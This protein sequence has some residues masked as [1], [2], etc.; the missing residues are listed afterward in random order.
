MQDTHLK[1][2]QKKVHFHTHRTSERTPN[3]PK[4][5]STPKI[6]HTNEPE[7]GTQ[8][9]HTTIQYRLNMRHTQAHM[10]THTHTHTHAQTC[11]HLY[12]NMHT[13]TVHTHLD[14]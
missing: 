3:I 14:K 9:V 4:A 11:T 7:I 13:H 10:H 2:K 8:Y 1:N 12:T 5:G 6:F